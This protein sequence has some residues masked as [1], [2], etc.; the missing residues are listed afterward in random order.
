[1]PAE[2]LCMLMVTITRLPGGQFMKSIVRTLQ[3][4]GLLCMSVGGFSQPQSTEDWSRRDAFINPEK[5]GEQTKSSWE[6]G[7]WQH[8]GVSGSFRFVVTEHK[9][10]RDKLYLQ[11]IRE[12]GEL[13][14]SLSVKELNMRP[15]YSLSSPVCDDEA[16]CRSISVKATHYY[17][18]STREFKIDLNGL[19]KYRFAF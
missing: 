17:E 10:K 8:K 12:S 15:E 13:A 11:W 5:I 2:I 16:T 3:C 18:Q 14:Y 9:P 4:V 19:G 6:G 1:M 7:A